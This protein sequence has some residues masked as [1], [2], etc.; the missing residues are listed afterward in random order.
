MSTTKGET[1]PVTIRLA[2][3]GPLIVKNLERLQNSRGEAIASKPTIA[4]CRCGGSANKPF[5]DGT[6]AKIDFSGEN[7][8]DKGADRQDAYAGGEV[9]IQDNRFLCAHIG[10]CTDNLAAVFRL[11]TEP[12]IDPD[13]ADGQAIMETI[14]KCPSGALGY[15]FQGAA[16]QEPQGEPWI[17]VSKD[18]PYFVRGD[19]ALDG[20]AWSA[21]ADKRRY[22]LCRCGASANKPFCDGSHGRVE[23]QDDGN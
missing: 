9:T 20:V 8:A 5:C 15:V 18:G 17:T 14:R 16:Y 10:E 11:G 2:P 13:G 21:S 12:W 19:V 3:K 6:H 23:F 4:L 22:A 7:T 1:E